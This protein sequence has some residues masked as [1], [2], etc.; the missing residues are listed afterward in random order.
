ALF[1][2]TLRH[3][4]QHGADRH[5]GP[6]LSSGIAAAVSPEAVEFQKALR[7]YKT[8]YRAYSYQGGAALTVRA[9][10]DRRGKQWAPGQFEVF[11]RIRK[12]YAAVET[13]VGGDAPTQE[14]SRFVSA[15]H[16]Y[17]NPD[18]EGFN[19]YN[20]ARID[21]LY[22]ALSAVKPNT[23]DPTDPAVVEAL[24][25]ARA[26]NSSDVAY[27]RA[28]SEEV[29][30]RV[31]AYMLRAMIRHR[32]DGPAFDA[33]VVAIRQTRVFGPPR[34]ARRRNQRRPRLPAFRRPGQPT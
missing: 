20:S 3:E 21:D 30:G 29:G 7:E 9:D 12:D 4:V 10:A 11:E 26:L 18:T 5:R 16:A 8:E 13:A 19:K 17:R 14:Q 2:Q 25:A 27:I 33:F 32:L 1:F 31:E 6:A 28:G 24:R 23:V 34:V 22:L 15:A